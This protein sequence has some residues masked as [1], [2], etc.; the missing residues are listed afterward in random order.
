MDDG[1]GRFQAS[2]F[3]LADERLP[4]FLVCWLHRRLRMKSQ[5]EDFMPNGVAV[6]FL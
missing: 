6:N 2:I 4:L 5:K 3:S 1:L